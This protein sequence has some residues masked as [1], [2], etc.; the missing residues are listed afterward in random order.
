[1][2]RKETFVLKLLL[3]SQPEATKKETAFRLLLQSTAT[4]STYCFETATE[5]ALFLDAWKETEPPESNRQSA[6]SEP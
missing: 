1:M 2:R 3:L 5:L 6:A 4:G